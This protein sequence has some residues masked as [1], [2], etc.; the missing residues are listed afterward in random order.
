M[1]SGNECKAAPSPTKE[2]DAIQSVYSALEPL[3]PDGRQRV[4]NYIVSLL[5]LD[6]IAAEPE[7]IAAE[8]APSRQMADGLKFESLAEL[9]EPASPVSNADK[10]LVVGAWL[11]KYIGRDS[12]SAQAI[13]T[14]LKHL[15]HGITNITN[16]LDQLKD[17]KPSHSS[18]AKKRFQP[19]GAQDLQGD[20]RRFTRS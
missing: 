1:G 15:G 10:A 5:N 17:M 4:V 14:E 7:E 20:C 3:D 18:T 19:A 8:A 12:F 16:A 13:N 6:F 9:Y 2:F 11:Q